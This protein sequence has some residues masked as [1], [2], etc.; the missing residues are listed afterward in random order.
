MRQRRFPRIRCPFPATCGFCATHRVL[1]GDATSP[2]A[3]ARFLGL[4]D[5]EPILKVTDPP[6]RLLTETMCRGPEYSRGSRRR[7]KL[8]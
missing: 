5:R 8:V 2:D 7:L 6:A 4:G 1:C 3:V